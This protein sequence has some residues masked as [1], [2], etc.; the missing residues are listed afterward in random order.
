M[1]KC[2]GHKAHRS[3]GSLAQQ[4]ITAVRFLADGKILRG[5]Y[6]RGRRIPCIAHGDGVSM[7]ACLH[8]HESIH[9]A[10]RLEGSH[11]WVSNQL[12]CVAA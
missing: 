11:D 4:E 5:Y 7:P 10:E 1:C 6:R 3:K 2:L 9:V 12:A 8:A